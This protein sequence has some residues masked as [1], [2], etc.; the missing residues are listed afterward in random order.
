MYSKMSLIREIKGRGIGKKNS[1][2]DV[3]IVYHEL[4]QCGFN[5]GFIYTCIDAIRYK[6]KRMK[7]LDRN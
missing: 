6:E 4:R 7:K 5:R 1:S 3:L 2:E